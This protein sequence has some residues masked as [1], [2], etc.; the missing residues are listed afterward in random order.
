MTT[1]TSDQALERLRRKLTG[2]SIEETI[3][4]HQHPLEW[5]APDPRITPCDDCRR[6]GLTIRLNHEGTA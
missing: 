5:S 6:L 4:R 2:P 1:L 3:C